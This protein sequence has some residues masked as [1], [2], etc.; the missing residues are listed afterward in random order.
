MASK[1]R[2]TRAE[3]SGR[4]SPLLVVVVMRRLKPQKHKVHVG[5]AR[6]WDRAPRSRVAMLVSPC[7]FDLCRLPATL[8][9]SLLVLVVTAVNC[10]LKMEACRGCQRQQR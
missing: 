2:T 9:M 3:P 4:D 7:W 1:A 10:G 6:N 5:D 8:A